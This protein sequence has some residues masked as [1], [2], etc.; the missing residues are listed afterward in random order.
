MFDV[1]HND[2]HVHDIYHDGI[3]VSA[4]NHVLLLV[5][6]EIYKCK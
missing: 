1:Y 6:W 2:V 5:K 3:Y 4:V